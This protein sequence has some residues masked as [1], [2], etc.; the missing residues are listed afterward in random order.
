MLEPVVKDFGYSTTFS[1][2]QFIFHQDGAPVHTSKASQDWLVSI[3][4]ESRFLTTW[5]RLPIWFQK[6][7]TLQVFRFPLT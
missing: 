5:H 4:S 1:S 7:P 6:N 2:Q 3:I